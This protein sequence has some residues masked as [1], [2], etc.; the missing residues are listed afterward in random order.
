MANLFDYLLWRGDVP[1]QADPFGEADNLVL[2]ELAYTDFHGVVPS[3]GTEI[4]LAE[5]RDAYFRLHSPEEVRAYKSFWA[6]TPFL[7]DGMASGRRFAG[8]KLSWYVDEVDQQK[9]SQMSALTFRLPDGSVYVAFRGTDGSLVG[10][11]EDFNFCYLSETE[12]QRR[13]VQYLNRVGQAVSGEL[14]VGGHSK[15]GN[16]AVYASA[17]CDE[18][19]QRRIRRVYT[20]DGP[21]FRRDVTESGSYLRILPRIQS[22]I[23]DTA[24]V[25]LLLTSRARH[26][27]VKS[28]A[29]GILQ[30]DGFSWQIQRNRFVENR[31]SAVS[32][33]I[34]NA[35][36]G[37]L[38]Q[39]DDEERRSFVSTVFSLFESTGADT[40][41]E[42]SKQKWKS[43][44]AMLSA[45]RGMP[46]EK[47]QETLRLL[48]QLTQSGGQAVYDRVAAALNR[49]L[50][51][52][53]GGGA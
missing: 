32:E 15:G 25:G 6:K 44:E 39:M 10:W 45:L 38:E 51:D 9:E 22:F 33:V 50:P 30:H 47:Y 42:I 23:P 27:V 14:T 36:G 1:L 20:N 31:L 43:L 17:F 41:G 24:I 11:K 29:V 52:P 35:L 19:V 53:K 46:K 26:R 12:G 7:M 5:A 8:T 2:A 40:F 34:G 21:G 4:P 18:A 48:G 3:D 16:L 28:S 13:A 37:W 49:F